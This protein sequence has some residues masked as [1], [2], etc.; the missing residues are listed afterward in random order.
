MQF[1]ISKQLEWSVPSVGASKRPSRS[2]LRR[3]AWVLA[4]LVLASL[5]WAGCAAQSYPGAVHGL[6]FDGTVQSIDLQ[7]HRLTLLPLKPSAP[8][9]FGFE[10]ATKFWRNG[11]PIHADEVEPGRSVRV[12]YHTASGEP[13][14]HHVYIQLS[15]APQH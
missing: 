12:H 7:N 11:I 10:S 6:T 4:G 9:V 15:Y 2:T 5:L 13:V 3:Q 1:S 8:V 14:A